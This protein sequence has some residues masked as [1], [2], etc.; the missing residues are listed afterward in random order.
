MVLL[1]SLSLQI[2]IL[3]K[4]WQEKINNRVFRWNLILIAIQIAYLFYKFND[5]PQQVP[6]YYS[7]PWGESQLTAASSLFLLPTFSIIVGLLNNMLAAF[8]LN[9]V[10]LLS[11]LLVIFSLV[12]SFLSL[13]TLLHIISLIS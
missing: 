8:F 2:S 13:V 9:T 11:R 3:G 12:Y 7:L 5:L 4:F 1:K 6:L 10:N